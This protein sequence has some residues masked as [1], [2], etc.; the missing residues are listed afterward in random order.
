MVE[1]LGAANFV[2]KA[3]EFRTKADVTLKGGFFSN[4]MSAKQDRKDDAKELYQ[5]AANCYK[6]AKDPEQA[7]EMYLKCVEC[8]AD[9]GF[10]ANH[11]KEAAMCMK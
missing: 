8:E 10:K 2:A 6:H 1:T 7:V 11:F 5:Q 9:E 3:Y 4:L